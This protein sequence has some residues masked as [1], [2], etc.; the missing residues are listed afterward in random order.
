MFVLIYECLITICT[1]WT[2]IES[3]ISPPPW[4]TMIYNQTS[5]TSTWCILQCFI[6]E[7][8]NEI[9]LQATYVTHYFHH[10]FDR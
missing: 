7:G 8:L 1:S 10:P 6:H 2:A 3:Q 4:I 5:T 9:S